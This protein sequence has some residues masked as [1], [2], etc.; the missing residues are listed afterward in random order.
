M[1]R[2]NFFA[3]MLFCITL[4]HAT[5]IAQPG[6]R[7]NIW[8]FGEEAGLDFTQGHPVALTDGAMK[9]F[10]GTAAICDVQGNLMFYTNGGDAP[11]EGGIW[12][13]YHQLMPNGDLDGAGGCGSAFQSSLI[14]PHPKYE[15]LYYLFTTD[16]IE[17]NSTG[18]LRYSVIDM[19]LDGGKGDVAVKDVLLTTPVDESLTAVQHANGMDYWIVAHKL[20]TDSFYVYHLTAHGITGLVKTKIGPSTPDY[21]GALKASTNGERLV[22]SGLNFTA[23]FH[24]DNQT[25]AISNYKN[26]G[27]GSYSACFSP[28]CELLYVANGINRKIFQF[29]LIQRDIASSAVIVGTTVSTGFGG[30]QLGPDDRI[31]I[32]RFVTSTHLGVIQ[33]PNIKG[34]GC[35]YVDD[36]IYLAGKPGKGGLPNFANNM[37]GECVAYPVENSSNYAQ[38]L[39][40]AEDLRSSNFTLA[41]QSTERNSN[42]AVLYKEADSEAWKQ[43]LVADNTTAI[44]NLNPATTYIA[45]VLPVDKKY[46]NYEVLPEHFTADVM[47]K[48]FNYGKSDNEVIATT[49]DKLDFLLYPNPARKSTTVKLDA[50]IVASQV[51]IYIM[52]MNG[53]II[54]EL[55]LDEVSGSQEIP[56]QLNGL[57]NGIYHIAV[58]TEES[59]KIEKLIVL[60]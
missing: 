9:A 34:T 32:A 31:Y 26:L 46:V 1:R 43:I 3:L 52:E 18:G 60:R 12:N 30:M 29:D 14:V 17:N 44:G 24:F 54:S 25:G 51:D 47:G 41:W 21:A 37:V 20:H 59:Y 15:E 23:L 13:R 28:N 55:N 42:Y 33:N 19:S 49:P 56:L 11:Y 39:I 50:G 22:Y 57:P 5:A 2:R 48:N 35:A 4:I 8:Y 27:I 7:A 58:Q 6:K 16:C 53:K 40:R 10:E 38:L 45:R 36:G